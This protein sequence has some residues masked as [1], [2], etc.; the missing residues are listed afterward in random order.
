MSKRSGSGKPVKKLVIKDLVHVG[1]VKSTDFSLLDL[2][3][4]AWEF[5]RG[6]R[7][8]RDYYDKESGLL[9]V[10]D[11]YSYNFISE[12]RSIDSYTRHIEWFNTDG[13][14]GETKDVTPVLNSKKIKQMNRD[15][16]QGRIDYLEAA[17]ENLRLAAANVPSPY[18]E[19][20]TAIADSIDVLFSHYSVQVAEYISRGTMKFENDV[21]GEVIPG[22]LQIL[23]I[24]SDV[25]SPKFPSGLTVKMSILYQLRGYLVTP[26][27]VI[28][29]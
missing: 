19:Q 15:F 16:R 13:T 23:E 21:I 28:E 2:D 5:L 26:G 24:P 6:A 14:V 27:D 4:S 11:R 9:A 10:R 25:P 17:A 3:S 29:E 8:K 22:I 1:D 12:G 20:Y 18:Y 7:T